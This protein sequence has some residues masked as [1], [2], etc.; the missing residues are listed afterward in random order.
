MNE[1][2]KTTLCRNCCL[3]IDLGGQSEARQGLFSDVP[4]VVDSKTAA[5]ALSVP[6][7][8]IRELAR[9]GE[10]RG[11]KVGSVWRFTRDAL[12][13]YVLCQTKK[14]YQDRSEL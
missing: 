13:E 6:E 9:N 4:E 12:R 8:T 14:T 3:D 2:R 10:I 1:D 5:M 11:F 7:R